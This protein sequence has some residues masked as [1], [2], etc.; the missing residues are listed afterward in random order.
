MINAAD[1]W[2]KNPETITLT[3]KEFEELDFAKLDAQ[4]FDSDTICMFF[5]RYDSLWN[6]Y[7]LFGRALKI[8]DSV[9]A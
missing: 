9:S 5:V 1:F 6:S 7:G 3:T 2:L 8:S 4:K